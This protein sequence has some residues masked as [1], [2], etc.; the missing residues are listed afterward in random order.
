MIHLTRPRVITHGRQQVR[1]PGRAAAAAAAAARGGKKPS[2]LNK[3]N[4]SETC[5]TLLATAG[6]QQQQSS[7]YQWWG[8][9]RIIKISISKERKRMK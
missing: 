4:P 1:A 9:F 2:G 3:F 5:S 8:E 6:R 7:T